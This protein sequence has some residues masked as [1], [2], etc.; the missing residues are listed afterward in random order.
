VEL[1]P[2]HEVEIRSLMEQQGLRPVGWYHSHPTFAPKP[3]AKDNSNQHNYQALFRDEASGFEPFVGIIIGPYDIALPNASSAS[4][5]FIVQEKSVGLLAYNIRYSLTA[6]ELP[7]EGLEQKVV[8]LLGMFKE[9]IGRIDFTELWRP[10]TTLS[11]GA[12]GG[13]PMTKLAKLRNALV[14]H[15]PS[16]KY[17]ESEDLL[18]RCAVAMQKSWG[19][20]LGFPS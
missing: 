15:L 4:T 6:M 10:F 9:D 5:V 20:D 16:E 13:G 12:T 2:E 3:S 1:D 8:E 7:C 17:S 14:S 11:Q 19:I 18:D